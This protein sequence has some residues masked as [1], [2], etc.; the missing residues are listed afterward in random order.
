[1]KLIVPGPDAPP[2]L[3]REAVYESFVIWIANPGQNVCVLPG[4][5][6]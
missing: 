6:L 4:Q 5:W 2:N 1:M 3:L